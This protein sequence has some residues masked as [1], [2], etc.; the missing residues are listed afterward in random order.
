M[1]KFYHRIRVVRRIV[2]VAIALVLTAAVALGARC[3][4]ARMQLLPAVMAGSAVWLALWS[5]ATLL[6]GRVYCSTVCPTGTLSDVA[7]AIRRALERRRKGV[8]G[9]YRYEAPSTRGRMSVLAVTA[10]CMAL[11]FSIV[12]SLL[13]PYSAYARIVGLARSL[14]ASPAGR[15]VGIGVLSAAVALATLAAVAAV[16]WRRGRHLCAQWCPVGS[17]LGLVSRYSLYHADVN[18]DLCVHCSRCV[19]NCKAGCINPADMTVDSSRC[20]VCFDCMDVCAT[21][22]MTYRRDRHRLTTP[23]LQP[24]GRPASAPS[25]ETRASGPVRMDRRKFLRLG[26]VAAASA[27]VPAA[28]TRASGAEPWRPQPLK[29]LNAPLPPGFVSR[30]SFMRRCTAC[31]ACV[32]ACPT[33][34]LRPSLRQY[35]LEHAMQPVMDYGAATCLTDCNRCTRVCPTGAIVPLTVGEKR[36]FVIGKA[37]IRLQNCLAYGLGEDCGRCARRCPYGAIAMTVFGDGRRGP[38]VDLRACTGCGQCE[39]VCPSEPYKAIVIEGTD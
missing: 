31:G 21:G 26:V 16:A 36:R 10:L 27:A 32:A 28:L 1:T 8:A 29:A 35:G 2:A 30:R 9:R 23:L 11:G 22:A 33:G 13:D 12:P 15:A 4:G 5:V 39:A 19:D 3:V 25:L 18:T 14:V 17:A 6:F 34:V 20:V 37:R 7:A 38:E 24:A